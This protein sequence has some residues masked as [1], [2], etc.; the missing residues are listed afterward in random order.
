MNKWSYRY[1]MYKHLETNLAKFYE[2]VR[3]VPDEIGMPKDLR[4]NIGLTGAVSSNHGL[5]TREIIEAIAKGSRKV[6]GNKALDDEVRRIVKDVYGDEYD[7]AAINTCEAALWVTF[8]VLASPPFTGRGDNYRA[9]YIAPYE[10]HMHHQAGYGRPFPP[11][12]KDLY[13]DRGATAGEF[14]FYGKRLNNLETVIVPLVGAKYE[15]HG[16]KSHPC[17]LL[18]SVDPEA[19]IERMAKVAEQQVASLSAF[20][21]LGYDTPGY[22]YGVKDNDGTPTLQRLIGEL[23]QKY[24]VPYINDNAWAVPFIGVDPRKVK[25]EIMMYSM[26]KASGA[27]TSGL[28]IGKEE[29]MVQIRRALGIQGERWGTTS[30]HGKSAYVTQDPGKEA[31][32][33]LIATLEILRDQPEK[34][35]KPVDEMYEIVKQEFDRINPQLKDGLSIFKS[36][37]CSSIEVN[38]ENTWKDGKMGIPIFPI[39]DMYAGTALTQSGMSAMGIVPTLAYDGNILLSPGLGTTDEEGRLLEEPTRYIVR[40]L[41]RLVEIL[42]KYARVIE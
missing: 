19:S 41:V 3:K 29:V 18:M 27:P 9:R 7:A 37:N 34:I 21:S 2:D 11:K 4:G 40:A 24:N 20:T 42:C 6:V 31:L 1:E 30:S 36:Y 14:G 38:Y 5:L 8:D 12:Y 33:G 13:A 10:R 22:G 39:E 16:I 23:A 28:I 25:A 35:T 32:L 17:P 15:V 26:D